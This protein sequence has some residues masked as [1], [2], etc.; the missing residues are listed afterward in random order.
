[1][2]G[3]ELSKTSRVI[4]DIKTLDQAIKVEQDVESGYYSVIHENVSYWIAVEEDV[5]E[6]YTKL[7]ET[8][9]GT[10]LMTTLQAIVEDSKKHRAILS[11]ISSQLDSIVADER[12]HERML[13]ELK[14]AL[15]KSR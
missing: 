9:P 4:K 10:Q 15:E 7:M 2:G 11:H 14:S 13:S 5:I 8:S 1:M 6:S 3:E 12:K